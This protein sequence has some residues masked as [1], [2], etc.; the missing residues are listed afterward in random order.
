MLIER[1]GRILLM[2]INRANARNAVNAMVSHGLPQLSTNSKVTPLYRSPYCRAVAE[3][4][5]LEWVLSAL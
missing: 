1:R 4:S 3:Y 2:T 5:A